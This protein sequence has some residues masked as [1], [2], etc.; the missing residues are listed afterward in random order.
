[1]GDGGIPARV[2]V[3]KDSLRPEERIALEPDLLKRGIALSMLDVIPPAGRFFQLLRAVDQS[4]ELLGVTSLMSARPFVSIKQLLGEGNHVGWDTAFYYTERADRPRVAAALL[5]AIARRSM[6]YGMFFGRIDDDVRTAL[7]LIRHRLLETDYR[8]GRIDCSGYETK[9]DFLA[10]HKRLRRH[11]RNHSKAGGTVHVRE[12]PVDPELARRFS[13]LVLATYRHHG[14]IGRWQFKEYAYQVCGSF[15]TNCEDTVHIYTENE[16]S[17]TGL[18]S[19][20]RH[21]DH[22]ELSEGGFDRSR[23]NHHAYEAIIAESVG[24]A[25]G[26]GLKSVG[27]GG[28]WNAAKDRYTDSNDRETVYLLQIYS[29]GL[30]YRLGG[31]RLSRWAF[32]KYFGG[33]FAGASGEAKVV[34]RQPHP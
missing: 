14:G 33:R 12:G 1:M 13:D 11:L 8:L 30:K 5:G 34:S 16:G 23:D 9:A 21:R 28:I 6:F 15:F 3:S 31:D 2:I 22:L 4:G 18:Q 17:V 29:N 24:V 19:F 20:V 25:V 27:Y 7:P 32:R 10:L 26:L